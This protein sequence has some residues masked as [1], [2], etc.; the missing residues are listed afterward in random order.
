MKNATAQ[1]HPREDRVTI[2]LDA[3]DMGSLLDRAVLG[4]GAY[5]SARLRDCRTDADREWTMKVRNSALEDM[6][7]LRRVIEAAPSTADEA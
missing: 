7:Q 5:Y 3:I 2:T 1:F 6:R 4:I